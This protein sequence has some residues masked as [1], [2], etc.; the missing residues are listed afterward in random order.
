MLYQANNSTKRI[1]LRIRR[2]NQMDCCDKMTLSITPLMCEEPPQYCYEYSPCGGVER[3]EIKREPP[4]T[5]VYDMFD[6]DELGNVCFLLDNLFAELPCGR[7]NA[8]LIAC[9]CEV[10]KFQ[11]DKRERVEVSQVMM[12]D[13]S[14]CCG[15]KYGC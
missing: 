12:D 3:K 8:K 4:L 7:Y 1:C 9:G 11:I 2:N 6:R 15:G 13:R 5:L 10:Y 14:D